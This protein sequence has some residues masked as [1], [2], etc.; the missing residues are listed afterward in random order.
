MSGLLPS[1]SDVRQEEG[2]PRVLWFDDEDAEQL[3][4]SLSSD[5]A[6][7]VLRDL[8]ESPATASELAD[9]VDTSLQ[10]V[11]YHVNNLQ[12][13]GLVDVV[14]T[15][16]S[17]KG[18]EMNVY[19]P[20]DDPLVVCVGS[21]DDRNGIFESLR[22]YVGAFALLAVTSALVQLAF[23]TAVS[24]VGGPGTMPRIGDS[25]GGGGGAL[26]GAIPPGVAFFAGGLLVLAAA[27]ALS[28]TNVL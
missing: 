19:G 7:T 12:S 21:T 20:T 4:G 5:T 24:D 23:Q 17:S 3:I 1:D 2:E 25:V 26:L 22:E 8:H 27:V 18:R 15:E 13:A 9:E 10:N 11:R 28:R 16:Y 14:G 6:R